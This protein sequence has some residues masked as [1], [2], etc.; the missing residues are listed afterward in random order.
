MNIT[1]IGGSSTLIEKYSV[2]DDDGIETEVDIP[3]IKNHPDWFAYVGSC[4]VNGIIWHTFT[5]I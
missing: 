3:Y 2:I 4:E 1:T 5:P